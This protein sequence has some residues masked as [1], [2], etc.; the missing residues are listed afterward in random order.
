MNIY[1]VAAQFNISVG[2]LR[3]LDKAGLL[4][5]DPESPLTGAMRFYLSKAKPLTVEQLVALIESPAIIEELGDKAGV[6]LAQIAALGSPVTPAPLE[7]VAEIDQAAHGDKEAVG[8][9]LP[10]LKATISAATQSRV[11][12]HYLAVRLVLGSAHGLRAYNGA[13]IARAFLNCRQHPGFAGWWRVQKT[14]AGRVTQYGTPK[15][16]DL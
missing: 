16:F 4:R 8:R 1:D 15:G 12:H 13:R 3:K 10:W 2:K 9:M 7:I 6:A 14:K 11:N 5:L